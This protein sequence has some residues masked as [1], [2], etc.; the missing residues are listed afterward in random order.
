M[1]MPFTTVVAAEANGRDKD[2]YEEY[3]EEAVHDDD[4][5]DDCEPLYTSG[6]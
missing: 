6:S 3:A 2:G 1:D 4:A 5:E